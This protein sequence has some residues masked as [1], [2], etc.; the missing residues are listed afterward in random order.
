MTCPCCTSLAL[1]IF[2]LERYTLIIEKS[3]SKLAAQFTM[4]IKEGVAHHPHSLVDPKPNRGLDPAAHVSG[5]GE[6]AGFR[7]FN[8]HQDALLQPG[9]FFPL[10]EGGGH[11][12]DGAG[13]RIRS[14]LR[15]F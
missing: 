2:V 8:L 4:I 13:T 1:R 11:L 10:P 14:I 3:I 12:R 7:R 5:R 9:G 15:S 6:P